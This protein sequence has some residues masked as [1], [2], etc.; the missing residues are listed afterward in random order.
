MTNKPKTYAANDLRNSKAEAFLA[1]YSGEPVKIKHNRFPGGHFELSFVKPA[2]ITSGTFVVTEGGERFKVGDKITFSD[3]HPR[4]TPAAEFREA[5]TPAPEPDLEIG[6]RILEKGNVIF[7]DGIKRV[8]FS[9]RHLLP[10]ETFICGRPHEDG[11]FSYL[12]GS[13]YCRCCQ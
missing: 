1:A 8:I 5:F 6:L 9:P 10:S 11:D 4:P 7:T 3:K 12:C 2:P 13:D